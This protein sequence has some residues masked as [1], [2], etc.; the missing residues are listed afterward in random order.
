MSFSPDGIVLYRQGYVTRLPQGE[1]E[2]SNVNEC[3]IG[4]NVEGIMQLDP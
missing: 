2:S 3:E 4:F 1:L